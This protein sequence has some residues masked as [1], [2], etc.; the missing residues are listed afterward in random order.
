VWIGP[1][2]TPSTSPFLRSWTLSSNTRKLM[3]KFAKRNFPS[4]CIFVSASVLWRIG[5]LLGNG[6]V[7]TFPWKRI[8]AEQSIAG[9][10]LGKHVPASMNR[11]SNRWTIRHSDLRVYSVHPEVIK[12]SSFVNSVGV[13]RKTVVGQGSRSRTSDRFVDQNQVSHSGRE[14][15]RSPVR[16]GAS[17]RQ[18]LTVSRYN[19]L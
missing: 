13:I 14:D 7:S 3:L 2:L 4:N 18:Q 9:Q 16:N 17:L 11:S 8:D 15:T 1:F 5:P 10:R 19:W 6:S 12:E